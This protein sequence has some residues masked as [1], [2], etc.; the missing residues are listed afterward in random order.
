MFRRRNPLAPGRWNPDAKFAA[1]VLACIAFSAIASGE[2]PYDIVLSGGRVIDPESGLD[3]VR[4]VG[5]RGGVIQ[6]VSAQPLTGGAVLDAT[7]LVVAPGFIDLHQHA[8]NPEDY[9]LKAQDGVT[10]VGELE[11]GTSDVDRW[12]SARAGKTPINF[13]VSVG[14]VQCRIAVMGGPPAFLPGAATAAATNRASDEQIAK[15]CELLERG[16]RRGA[17]AVGFGIQYTPGASPWE[18][19]QAFRVAAKYRAS[20]H[21]HVRNKGD[22]GS[23]NIYTALEEIIAAS[24]ITGAPA[25]ICHVQSSAGPA[26]PRVLELIADARARGLDLTTE[27][28][29]YTASMTEISSAIFD[30]GWQERF[31]GIGYHDLQWGATGERL[32]EESFKAYRSSGGLVI[33]HSNTEATVEAAV[34]SPVTM[35]ASDGLRGHPRD[36]GTSARILGHYVRERKLITLTQAI[37]KLSLMPA[38]RLE[39]RVPAMRNKGRIRVG[40]D[41]DLVIFDPDKVIDRATYEQPDLPSAG[42]ADVLVNGVFVVKNGSFQ[43]GVVPG[44]AV[45]APQN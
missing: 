40:A 41:A 6:A 23:Q 14:H 4:E 43:A 32:T 25:Q 2:P 29:P 20:C 3:A 22:V 33:I 19:V 7:G 21:I 13:A 38:R 10:T 35:V 26:T 16:L 28:Y 5:I 27:C 30:P 8:Q 34:A 11:V 18:I 15:I 36:A 44:R 37:D 12:Y 24:A 17:V 9:Q 31:N 42:I 1:A 45:R 39:R